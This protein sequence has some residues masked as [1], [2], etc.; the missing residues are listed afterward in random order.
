M[1]P[2]ED[3]HDGFQAPALDT[4]V[5][6]LRYSHKTLSESVVGKAVVQ[7]TDDLP[8]DRRTLSNSCSSQL[9]CDPLTHSIHFRRLKSQLMVIAA[10]NLHS[11]KDFLQW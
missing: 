10:S 11:T 4:A 6:V 5:A 9:G 1:A 3:S 7:P 2:D 8:D